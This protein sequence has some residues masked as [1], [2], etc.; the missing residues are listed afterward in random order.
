MFLHTL[1][2]PA[3][4]LFSALGRSRIVAPFYLAGG[5][6]AA[7]HLGHRVSVDLDFFC[8][9]SYEPD[10]LVQR[11]AQLGRL[12]VQQQSPGTLLGQV[13]DTRVS[14]FTYPY[15]LLD[16]CTV[17]EN[18]QVASLLDIGLMK[19]IAIHQRGR[20]R[21][22]VDLFH[23]CHA[24]QE[25][26]ELL[27]R[28]P[29]KFAEVTYPSYSL[30]RSLTYFDDAENDPPPQMLVPWDWDQTKRFFAAEVGPMARSLTRLQ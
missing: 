15:R 25:L 5:S 1:P 26:P 17:C 2:A 16:P 14:F 4:Q 9:Q 7:L 8:P 28:I 24:G 11:L 22:F 3:R 19:L 12:I 23:I 10:P 27:R 20:K 29:E 21:D 30:L 18:V 13:N 6:A